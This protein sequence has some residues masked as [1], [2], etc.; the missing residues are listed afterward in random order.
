MAEGPG[1]AESRFTRQQWKVLAILALVNF[2]NYVD[3]QI[4]F[5]LFP[6]IRRDFGLTFFQLGSLVTAF[7]IVLALATVPLGMLADR[8][9]RKA[10]ISGGVIF[11]SLATFV[12]G[13][14]TSFRF[15]LSARALVG[16]GEAAYTPAGTAIISATFPKRVR[17]RVQAV[18][19]T[20]MFIGGAVGIALGGIVAGFVG[21]RLAF[22]LV[23]FPGLLLGLLA[24]GLPEV[25]TEAT[26]EPSFPIRSLLRYRSYLL[27]LMG[28]WFSTFAAYSYIT[29]GPEFVQDF[30]HFTP[31]ETGV[32]LG[33]VVIVA[34]MSGVLT[35]AA[36]AD[37]FAK[38]GTWGRAIT[39]P[40]GFV[41]SAPF[42]YYGLHAS[43]KAEFMVLFGIG[44]FFLTWYHGP[45]TAT[46]HDL[47]PARGHATAMGVYYL[48]VNLFAIAVA[49]I[50]IGRIADR[51]NLVTALH[52]AIGAQLFGALFFILAI[53]ALKAENRL[54]SGVGPETPGASSRSLRRPV[55][56]AA[57][58]SI[59]ADE[60]ST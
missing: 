15:L 43:S 42:V 5:P 2:V 49:P 8:T 10:V 44:T 3:R 11:W 19:D 20:G 7:T 24:L 53:L 37:R 40:I 45:V 23:G 17:A 25:K 57:K 26:S 13:M 33:A 14:A 59:N 22:F 60:L 47:I 32:I 56:P 21:W 1:M 9:S 34:G 51:K 46:I 36:L 58:P 30:L 4:L 41:I 54:I 31:R 52:L 35:G 6:F 12:S 50:V 55:L 16:V 27:I 29:W 38:R 18:F 48:F 28:G 39:V